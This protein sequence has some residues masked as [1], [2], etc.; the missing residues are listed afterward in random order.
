MKKI[1]IL[2]ACLL[3]LAPARADDAL[4]TDAQSR[5]DFIVKHA[6]KLAAGEAQAAVQISAA[7]QVNGN[8]VLAA[9]CRSSDGR[10]ALALWGSTLLAQ[11]NLTPLAQRLAQLALGDDGKHDA[12]AWFNE[13]NGD[14]YRHAQTLGCYTGALNRALQ[15]TD[16][17]AARSGELLRQTAT[18][19]GVAE[20][21]AAA[22]PAADAP[23][24]IRWV[25]GQLAPALQ[26]PGDSA[27]RLRAAALPPDADAAAVKAF[28]SGWQQGN[29]P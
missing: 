1:L 25:Y 24:K 16:D 22:A 5:R 28:E 14:D 15:S 20:L 8:A 21:A 13:K 9:L 29:T 4:A 7:L 19:A 27:S 18:A 2:T 3:A 12:T 17:A 26:N 11:H 10:D 6:G 23:A